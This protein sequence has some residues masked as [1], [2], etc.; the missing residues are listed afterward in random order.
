MH[1]ERF[2]NLQFSTQNTKGLRKLF[3]E[4][5]LGADDEYEQQEMEEYCEKKHSSHPMRICIALAQS[6]VDY[7]WKTIIGYEAIPFKL[8][9]ANEEQWTDCCCG[10]LGTWV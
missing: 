8:I 4:M 1:D 5:L 2:A 6:L 3:W 7:K 10:A 9:E